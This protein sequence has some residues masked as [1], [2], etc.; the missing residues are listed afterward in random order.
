MIFN[1]KE[2]ELKYSIR[3]MI[4]YENITNKNFEPTNLSDILTFFYCIVVTSLKDYSY[5][6][7]DFLDEIDADPTKLEKL[8]EW[9]NGNV[10]NQNNFKKN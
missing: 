2:I 9:L 1:N 5:S 7:D 8:T 10:L 4:M 6:F 3:A